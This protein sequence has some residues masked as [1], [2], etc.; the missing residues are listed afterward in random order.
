MN[1]SVRESWWVLLLSV[2]A[3]W[4]AYAVTVPNLYEASVPVTT[5]RDAAFVEALKAVAVRVSGRRDA[6]VRLGAAL[7]DPRQYVQRFGLTADNV[8]QVGFDSV[9]I[10]KLLGQADLPVWGRERPATLLL[11]QVEAPDGSSYWV[12]GGTT[13]AGERDS[14]AKVATLR[15]L[16]LVW[17]ELSPQDRDQL[18]AGGSSA[19]LLQIAARYSANAA[20]LGKARSDGAGGMSVHWTLA[21]S[22]GA[23]EASGSIEDGVHLA[24]D[25]FARVYSTSGTSLDSVTVEISGIDD[26]NA[27]ATMLNYLEGMTLVRDVAV[28]Q[29]LGATMRFKL[30]VRGDAGTLQRALALDGRLVPVQAAD[31]AALPGRLQFRY[32]P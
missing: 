18:A 24:A 17:P 32:Q 28:E 1:L 20:L 21:S 26:L 30:A 2:L 4:P 23:A 7:N 16:P 25:T 5:G 11:L 14:I 12:D 10:D 27:Y 19:A 8:L 9:S 6:A 29:V 31:G 13:N 3:A 15:G 22:E